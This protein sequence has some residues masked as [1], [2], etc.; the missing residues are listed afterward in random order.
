MVGM[1]DV[2]RKAGVS[3]STVSLVVNDTGYVSDEM[4]ARV[5]S[6]MKQL[7]YV[8]R[9][10]I[11]NPYRVRSNT[12]GVILPTVQHPFFATMLESLQKALYRRGLHTL[13][14][15]AAGTDAD[16]DSSADAGV[17]QY[18]GMLKRH[19]VDAIIMGA[20]TSRDEGYWTAIK[21]PI[22][23]FDRYLGDGIPSVGS[24]HEQGGELAAM[25]FALSGARHVVVLGGPRS[26][27]E[28][29]AQSQSGLNASG[30]ASRKLAADSPARYQIALEET[31]DSTGIRHDYIEIADLAK[32]QEFADAARSVLERFPDVDAIVAPDLAAALCVQEAMRR[33]FVV[34]SSLQ[35]LAYDGTY[36]TDAAG[37]RITS[38][39]QGFDAIA[40]R[41]AMRTVEQ[42]E[43]YQPE[44]VSKLRLG[45][46]D[47]SDSSDS[48]NG[49]VGSS[50]IGSATG[51]AIRGS[52]NDTVIVPEPEA[53]GIGDL[54]PMKVKIGETTL[55]NDAIR[56][57]LDGSRPQTD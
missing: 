28:N 9:E 31:L 43:R 49:S 35:I 19:L 14:C 56:E 41:I 46:S 54:I 12:V 15:I 36:A 16:N 18:V 2:A 57:L 39:L 23:A 24:D 29:A 48:S 45:S 4:R 33:G 10:S 6:A 52:D 5:E 27:L 51:S 44:R 30:A 53:A 50:A 11:R 21:R 26:Q 47:S 34:P 40:E 13:L 38:I 25:M 42:I 3:L 8:P 17:E 20:H 7:S 22:V 37:L 32:I 55:W 1:R